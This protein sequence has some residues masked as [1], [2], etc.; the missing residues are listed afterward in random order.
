MKDL[1]RVIPL[2]ER[3][4]GVEALIALEADETAAEVGGQHL[5]D[6]GLANAGLAFQ[7]Q[8][9]S[10]RE[11][12]KNRHRKR[13]VGDVAPAREQCFDFFDGCG[14]LKGHECRF[15]AEDAY[16]TLYMRH[17]APRGA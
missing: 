17:L 8:R 2:V 4:I 5:G 6:L 11:R 7:E 16:P 1:L 13:T 14:N 3:V 15:A 10:Q 12:E 9:F